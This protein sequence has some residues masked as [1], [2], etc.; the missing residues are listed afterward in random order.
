MHKMPRTTSGRAGFTLL[1]ALLVM[2]LIGLM[3][4]LAV[5]TLSA[6]RHQHQLQAQAEG[7]WSTLVLARSEALRRQ[8]RVRVCVRANGEVRTC[9]DSGL[10]QQG[11]LVF[12][13]ANDNAQLDAGEALIEE[14]DAVPTPLRLTV[15]NTVKAYFSYSAEGRSA[16]LHGAFMAGTW[17]FCVPGLETGWQVVSN[18]LG[19]PRLEKVTQPGCV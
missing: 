18:A 15:T 4:S 5:P 8:Q 10:W 1:E 14:R 16:T 9:D 6:L 2:A 3:L 13:D 11:W 17:R 19:R 12:A 7:L